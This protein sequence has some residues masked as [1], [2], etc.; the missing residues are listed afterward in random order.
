MVTFCVLELSSVSCFPAKPIKEPRISKITVYH[1]KHTKNKSA[2]GNALKFSSWRSVDSSRSFCRFDIKFS[3]EA[4]WVFSFIIS[5]LQNMKKIST[6]ALPNKKP[7]T[8]TLCIYLLIMSLSGK[9]FLLFS[10]Q[11]NIDLLHTNLN[12]S[13]QLFWSPQT[14]IVFWESNLGTT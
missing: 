5:W 14:N 13:S 10:L 1:H 3:R 7:V 4:S 2:K 6:S 9:I 12:K 8:K 11:L